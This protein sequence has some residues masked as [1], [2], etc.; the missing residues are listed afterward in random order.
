MASSPDPADRDDVVAAA[1]GGDP[2]QPM[3]GECDPNVAS[4]DQ[5]VHW[6]NSYGEVL[7]LEE[8]VRDQVVQLSASTAQ[9]IRREID[10]TFL[11]VIT[12]QAARFRRRHRIWTARVAEL[13]LP[14][15]TA[16]GP[17]APVDV[18][19]GLPLD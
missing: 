4:L 8:S 19:R 13:H 10:L 15:T 9:H 2:D 12:A 11:P 7:A 17:P 18:A 5:A 3:D 1:R 14:P 16:P 6:R